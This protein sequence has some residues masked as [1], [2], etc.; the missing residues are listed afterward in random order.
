M[1]MYKILE[2]SLLHCQNVFNKQ[3]GSASFVTQIS[4]VVVVIIIIIIVVV[5][6]VVVVVVCCFEVMTDSS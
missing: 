2:I 6:V 4:C 5:V 1:E 3:S